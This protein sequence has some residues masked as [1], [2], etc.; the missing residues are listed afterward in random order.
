MRIILNVAHTDD[1]PG[2]CSPD[3]KFREWLYSTEICERVA[4]TLRTYGYG[5]DIIR[6]KT[7]Y[8]PHKGLQQVCDD[9]NKIVAKYGSKNCLF[10]SIH[11]NAASNGKWSTTTGWSVYTTKGTTISDK[12]ADDLYWAAKLYLEPL[13]KKFRTDFSDGDPDIEENFYVC[14]YANCAA[15]LTENFFQDNKSDL[16]FLTSEKGKQAIVDL[17]I[18]GILAYIKNQLTK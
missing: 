18:D 2:K 13:G 17:H 1:T 5:V 3:G 9:A 16:E 15:V 8:G 6:Q 12:L 11:V 4:D 10:V 14:H 7:Y